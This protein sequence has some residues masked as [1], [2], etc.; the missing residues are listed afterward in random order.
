[1]VCGAEFVVF[2]FFE[3]TPFAALGGLGAFFVVAA[4]D[5]VAEGGHF[6]RSCVVVCGVEG[7]RESFEMEQER[8]LD[9]I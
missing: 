6:W 8:N 4:L 1:M 2:A 5:G 9:L 3:E 7:A